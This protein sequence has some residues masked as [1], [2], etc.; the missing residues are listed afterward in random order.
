MVDI[1]RDKKIWEQVRTDS[2]YKFLLDELWSAY[3]K[4]CKDKEIPMIK[5]SDEVD[6]LY[7][8]SRAVY[9]EKFF[10]RRHQLSVYTMLCLIY[11]E[12]DE[13]MIKLQDIVCDMCN[14]HSWEVPAHRPGSNL[15]KRDGL[16]LFSCET[17]LYLAEIKQLFI[18]RLHPLVIERIT[19]EIDR[20]ILKSFEN[21]RTWIEDLKSNWAA[22]CGGCLGLTFMYESAE[23]FYNVKPRID[24]MMANYLNGI[25]DDGTTSEGAAYWNYGMCFYTM[26]YEALRRVTYGRSPSGFKKDKI[27]KFAEF[28]SSI[29]LSDDVSTSF[30]DSTKSAGCNLWLVHFLKKEF[31]IIM[32]PAKMTYLNFEQTSTLIR[33]FMYYNPEYTTEHIAPGEKFFDVVGWYIK[34]TKTYGFA[35]KGGHNAEEH[36]HNDIGSFIVAKDD[37][38]ILA[39]LGCAQYTAQNFGAD[40]YKILNNSS[41][42][43]SVPIVN[44]AEQGTG[45]DYFGTI[46]VEKDVNIDMSKAYPVAISKFNRN[47]KL[48]DN[49]VTLKDTFDSGLDITERFV[50][51]IEPNISDDMICID[52]ATLTYSKGWTPK[53]T[54]EK[55]PNHDGDSTRCVYLIDFV[56]TQKT[57]TFELKVKF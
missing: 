11:P 35:T 38:Q 33:A 15:N 39:D 20:R 46:S 5:F 50:T 55:I 17:G 21:E 27:K 45:K 40:R 51:E 24:K 22:V 56:P 36:N 57:D 16:C 54:V 28:Y 29:C 30:S 52:C 43:H 26:Y 25:G 12:K 49:V 37:K 19:E 2:K 32:P 7:T 14:E 8:G 6:F 41:R 4:Y 10:A 47:F 44:G 53:V 9:N 3:D 42:G 48:S 34:R 1:F 31:D 23:R 13:Y 18:D